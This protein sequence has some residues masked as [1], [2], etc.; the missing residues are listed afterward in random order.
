MHR[1]STRKSKKIKEKT[2]EKVENASTPHQITVDN[3]RNHKIKVNDINEKK[4]RVNG[5]TETKKVDKP[6]RRSSMPS[7]GTKDVVLDKPPSP[8]RTKVKK[9]RDA[10]V[11]DGLSKIESKHK[12]LRAPPVVETK[13]AS[14]PPPPRLERSA[15]AASF[16]YRN[17]R[18]LPDSK[19]GE[20]LETIPDEDGLPDSPLTR[21]PSFSR[22]LEKIATSFE[23]LRS[24]LRRTLSFNRDLQS[25]R[26][27][28][29]TNSVASSKLSCRW[30]ASLQ[31][32][33][34]IDTHVS[35]NDLSFVNYDALNELDP[36][37][38]PERKEHALCRFCS[39]RIERFRHSDGVGLVL[40]P[41]ICGR[42]GC[43]NSIQNDPMW[44]TK[45]NPDA[46]FCCCAM[47][48]HFVRSN[49]LHV[50]RTR[51][52]NNQIFQLV[53]MYEN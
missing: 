34:E 21:K 52:S 49:S 38:K 26:P 7:N 22:R 41:C 1:G 33:Q 31:S 19:I 51:V 10:N 4:K 12:K 40:K 14:P 44:V 3:N 20:D 15:S 6:I 24:G 25:R 16:L 17:R 42:S 13:P 30:S 53:F 46:L 11:I 18:K 43:I 48:S 36:K 8:V 39:D 28:S 9:R 45:V 5:K 29:S 2:K 27:P 37:P 47:Q 23:T 50:Q 35:Y 32:L